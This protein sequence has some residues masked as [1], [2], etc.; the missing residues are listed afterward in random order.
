MKKHKYINNEFLNRDFSK[1]YNE[2]IIKIVTV[3]TSMVLHVTTQ[4]TI[5]PYLHQREHPRS[6][7]V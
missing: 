2:G 4:Q 1:T 6:Q 3:L 5:R 7:K